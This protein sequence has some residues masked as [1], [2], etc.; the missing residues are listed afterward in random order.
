MK[1]FMLSA[2][3]FFTMVSCAT[4]QKDI[5]LYPEQIKTVYFEV[6]KSHSEIDFYIVLTEALNE[7]I[8]FDTIYFRSHKAILIPLNDLTYK[9]VCN[10]VTPQDLIM[11]SNPVS[12]F[13]NTTPV[14]HKSKFSLQQNEAMLSY[15]IK[16][17]PFYYKMIN[18]IEKQ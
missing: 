4:K 13:G 17:K 5:K 14:I 15:K 3:V 12:E 2:V 10:N 9:A 11:S 16:N 1:Q 18:I 6:N 7:K 8:Q